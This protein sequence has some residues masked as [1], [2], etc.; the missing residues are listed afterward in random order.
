MV[1]GSKKEGEQVAQ[2][3]Y[4]PLLSR[5]SLSVWAA[6]FKKSWLCVV[7]EIVGDFRASAFKITATGLAP[8]DV[9]LA[10]S[11]VANPPFFSP[12]PKAAE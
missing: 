9:R 10:A 2:A 1:A 8:V 7:S 5:L 12:P 4:H 3:S 11:R 6:K